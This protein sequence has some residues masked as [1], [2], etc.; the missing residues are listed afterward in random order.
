[1]VLIELAEHGNWV[2]RETFKFGVSQAR[3]LIM[4]CILLVSKRVLAAIDRVA[5]SYD[6]I[7]FI[8]QSK[9]LA[10]INIV[11]RNWPSFEITS[12]TIPGCTSW[13]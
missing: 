4:G 11:H 10:I 5:F 12:K 1:M 3:G 13:G 6:E 8:E 7:I 9:S 2:Y